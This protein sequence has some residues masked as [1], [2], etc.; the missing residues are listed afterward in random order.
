M[1]L[2]MF[3]EPSH[4]EGTP[5]TPNIHSPCSRDSRWITRP[6]RAL[7]GCG[8]VSVSDVARLCLQDRLQAYVQELQVAWVGGLPPAVYQGNRGRPARGRVRTRTANWALG[9]PSGRYEAFPVVQGTIPSSRTSSATGRCRTKRCQGASLSMSEL[10]GDVKSKAGAGRTSYQDV[11]VAE[12]AS[13]VIA[14]G[15]HPA[16]AALMR[17]DGYAWH[18]YP[19]MLRG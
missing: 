11:S 16:V 8:L 6:G 13:M 5:Q 15:L 7:D 12:R 10:L 18:F 17:D 9:D 2:K 19:R 4:Q 1:C 3:I 14:A